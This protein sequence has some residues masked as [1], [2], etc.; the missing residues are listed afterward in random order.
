MDMKQLLRLRHGC[1]ASVATADLLYTYVSHLVGTAAPA[2]RE[3]TGSV[4]KS[5]EFWPPKSWATN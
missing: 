5:G 4:P 1:W 3:E 2:I